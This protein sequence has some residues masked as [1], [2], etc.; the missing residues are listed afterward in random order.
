M[1]LRGA[2]MGCLK[3]FVDGISSRMNIS[4]RDRGPFIPERPP[5]GRKSAKQTQVEHAAGQ[6]YRIHV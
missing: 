5:Q 4:I 6:Y 2:E 1:V 3:Q